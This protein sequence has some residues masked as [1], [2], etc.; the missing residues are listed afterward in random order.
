DIV[1]LLL[2]LGA[3]ANARDDEGNTPLNHASASTERSIVQ[4]LVAAGADPAEHSANR[5]KYSVPILNVRNCVASI[6]YYV[7]KL[8][9]DEGGAGGRP[10]T[11]AWV[12]RDGVRIFLCEAAQG[13]PGTWISIF[14]HDVDASMPTIG[15]PAPSSANRQR[16]IPGACAR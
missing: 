13:A 15:A 11:F 6:G 7:D 16:I 3:D 9:F 5:F 1:A 10:P 12:R 4:L 14:I 8:G 2:E